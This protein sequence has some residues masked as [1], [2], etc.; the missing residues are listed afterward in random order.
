MF[1]PVNDQ[2]EISIFVMHWLFF[3]L[4]RSKLKKMVD[5]RYC[6]G[7]ITL[8]EEFCECAEQN[9]THAHKDISRN[10]QYQRIFN[11]VST[12]YTLH[13]LTAHKESRFS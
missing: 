4:K 9:I 3:K 8:S 11:H 10:I 7:G 5:L 1:Y 6:H 13:N 12:S 2:Y